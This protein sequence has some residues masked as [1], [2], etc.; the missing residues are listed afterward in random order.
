MTSE[1]RSTSRSISSSF[2]LRRSRS[3]SA[4]VFTGLDGGYV[5]CL[6]ALV[7]FFGVEL[8]LCALGERAKALALDAGV[9]HEE[10]LAPLV[11][12]D[13]AES[14]VIVEPLHGSGGH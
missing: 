13:E 8:D 6:R 14:L 1:P 10:V 4:W 2:A 3:L 12:R 9:M 11:G 5:Y 7:A